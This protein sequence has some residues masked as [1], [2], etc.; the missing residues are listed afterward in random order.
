[1]KTVSEINSALAQCTGTEGYRFNALTRAANMVYTDGVALMA[2]MCQAHWLIDAIVSH[3]RRC[4]KDEM[5]Q[6]MQFWTLK[7][8]DGSAVLVCER[9]TDDVF[10]TQKIEFTDF[11]Q[12]EMKIWIEPGYTS[13]G[14]G[15]PKMVMVAMLP[16][17]R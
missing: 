14:D 15:E 2:E 3:Q 6:G 11:P 17:E 9:D 7:V 16:Q 5:L 12:P 4:M 8:K 10:L 1:M 13:F